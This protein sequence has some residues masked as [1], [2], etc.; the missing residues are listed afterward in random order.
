MLSPGGRLF[1]T[2]PAYQLLFSADDVTAGH[3]RRYTISSLARTLQRSKFQVEFAS[4]I[5]APLPPIVFALRTA[6]SRL[7]L[8]RGVDQERDAA[9]HAPKG[10]AAQLVD[11]LLAAELKQIEAGRRLPFGLSCLCVAAKT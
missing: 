9:E 3:F 10:V 7:G 4:Y 6:P 8:R 2:V 11:H 5:F 1:L